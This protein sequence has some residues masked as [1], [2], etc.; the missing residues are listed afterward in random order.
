MRSGYAV[1]HKIRTAD[2]R[3]MVLEPSTLGLKKEIWKIKAPRKLKHFLWQATSGFLATAK[4]LKDRHCAR[5]SCCMRCGAEMESINHT[6][7]ECPPALQVWALSIIPTSPGIFPC[8]SLYANVDFLLLRAKAKGISNEVMASF[9]WILWYI[10]KA[11][12]EKI[13]SNKDITPLDTLQFATKEAESWIL[14][15]KID[16]SPSRLDPRRN[17][18]SVS[19]GADVQL[20]AVALPIRCIVVKQQGTNWFRLRAYE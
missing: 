4:Q 16:H 12:N 6:L 9:P 2:P 11:R 14:A 1:A 8:T 7:F 15:Q 17:T 5:D 18:S 20:C 3:T 13:F 19:L 10:W